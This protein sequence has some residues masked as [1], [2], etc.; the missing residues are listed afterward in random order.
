MLSVE[1]YGP[2]IS[3]SNITKWTNNAKSK[4]WLMIKCLLQTSKNNSK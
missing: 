3:G 2:F 4:F 1:D